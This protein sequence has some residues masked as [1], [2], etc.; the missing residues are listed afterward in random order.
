MTVIRHNNSYYV[1]KPKYTANFK[2][3][4]NAKF[5]IF[6]EIYAHLCAWQVRRRRNSYYEA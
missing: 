1:M 3:E 6:P 4:A 2:I 5:A